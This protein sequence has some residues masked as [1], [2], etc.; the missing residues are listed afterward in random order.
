VFSAIGQRAVLGR[1]FLPEDARPG[2]M[3][4]YELWRNRRS[5]MSAVVRGSIRINEVP[6][7]AIGVMAPGMRLQEDSSVWIPLAAAGAGIRRDYRALKTFGRLAPEGAISIKP[8]RR[9]RR[10]LGLNRE[11]R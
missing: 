11:P 8:S 5:G 3:L 2:A 7:V 1:D 4:S 10:I 9:R 6:V